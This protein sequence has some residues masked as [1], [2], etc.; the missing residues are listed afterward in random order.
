MLCKAQYAATVP[1]TIPS[2]PEAAPTPPGRPGGT[3][4]G[5]LERISRFRKHPI[6][7]LVITLVVAVILAY[8]IQRFI[9]KPYR[10]PSASM[11]RTLHISDR[12]LAV[13][14]IYRFENPHRGDIL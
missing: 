5:M 9:V 4:P 1:E 10:I 2:E 12:V 13:R 8:G 7:D 6:I 14:F 11:E 3:P